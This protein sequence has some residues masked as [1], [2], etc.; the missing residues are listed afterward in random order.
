V[1]STGA[2]GGVDTTVLTGAGRALVSLGGAGQARARGDAVEEA[3]RRTSDGSAH[4]IDAEHPLL[5]PR[6]LGVGA[7]LDQG[8]ALLR[9]RFRR[10]VGLAA[11]LFVPVQLLDLVLRLTASEPTTTAEQASAAP[12]LLFFGGSS[13][14]AVLTVALQ[15][16]ALSILGIC[17]GHLVAR[18]LEGGDASFRTL[19]GVAA[20][21]C[22]VALLL[23]PLSMLVRLPFLLVPVVG[24]VIG[25]A[26]VF[27][28][29]VVAGAE[30]R[31]P[32]AALGR[33]F[34]LTRSAFGPAA[35]MAL[36]SLC[37]TQVVRI[38]L[39]AGPFVLVATFSP[40]EGLLVAIEQLA[41]LVQLV[42]QPLTACIAASAYL[43]L[44]ARVEGLDLEARRRA[45]EPGS[46][47]LE[48][49]GVAG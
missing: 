1:G 41:S 20:R 9:F 29:S 19:L 17:V 43:L 27:I 34:R 33:N 3:T 21:R 35:V 7:A 12:T 49:S 2:E 8:F 25:D 16:V 42:L 10:L 31:R 5:P 32:I 13:D 4:P 14:W 39:Y 45:R 47:Q 26:F 38:S 11:C 22:W 23:V 48:V 36:G 40:P 46:V 37:I 28:A 24:F 44:R 18:L 6:R 15:A 30:G